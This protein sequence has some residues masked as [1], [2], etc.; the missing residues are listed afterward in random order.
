[1]SKVVGLFYIEICYF[2]LL[3]LLFCNDVHSLQGMGTTQGRRLQS[4]SYSLCAC[5]VEITINPGLEQFKIVGTRN[6]P[7]VSRFHKAAVRE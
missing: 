7:L 5:A 1:M 4:K 6:H 3:S 2:F